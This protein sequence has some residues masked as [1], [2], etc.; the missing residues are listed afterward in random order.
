MLNFKIDAQ[1]SISVVAPS[2]STDASGDSHSPVP[3]LSSGFGSFNTHTESPADNSQ[4]SGSTTSP[5]DRLAGARTTGGS[6]SALSPE[7]IPFDEVLPGKPPPSSLCRTQPPRGLIVVEPAIPAN[8]SGLPGNPSSP[9]CRTQPPM[10]LIVAESLPLPSGP[11]RSSACSGGGMRL[12]GGAQLSMN[13][14]PTNS[15]AEPTLT[16]SAAGFG[17][18]LPAQKGSSSRIGGGGGGRGGEISLVSEGP[19]ALPPA[20]SKVLCDAGSLPSFAIEPDTGEKTGLPVLSNGTPAPLS[21][22]GRVEFTGSGPGSLPPPP[23]PP[24]VVFDKG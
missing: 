15:P 7:P 10:G 6:I 12:L 21:P 14:A 20:F 1:Q 9:L 22:T 23:P 16:K 3:G 13:G 5:G 24:A 2:G 17:S 11:L 4:G 8:A 18:P 19:Q